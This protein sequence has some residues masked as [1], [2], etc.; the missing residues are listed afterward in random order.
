M[1]RGA[2]HIH[3]TY[4]DGELTLAELRDRYIAL[5]CSFLAMTDHAESFTGD[6]LRSYAAECERLSTPDFALVAGLEFGCL[7]RMHVLGFGVTA[8]APSKEPQAVFAHVARH[9][10]VSVI[11]H[12]MDTAFA[13]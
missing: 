1:L 5:G 13:R 7:D 3:S 11:A 9:G 2:I 12:P 8:L 6:T 10:G 4:S